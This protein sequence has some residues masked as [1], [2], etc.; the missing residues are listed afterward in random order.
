[1]LDRLIILQLIF[2]VFSIT[3]LLDVVLMLS[4]EIVLVTNGS[5]RVDIIYSNNITRHKFKTYENW[6]FFLFFTYFLAL[7]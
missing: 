6:E 4:R 1:M 7:L 3:C 2:F 5:K